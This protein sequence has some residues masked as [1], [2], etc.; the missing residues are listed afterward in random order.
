MQAPRPR[1]VRAAGVSPQGKHP[2]L[3]GPARP[4]PHQPILASKL[5]SPVWHPNYVCQCPRCPRP[6]LRCLLA[7]HAGEAWPC[8]G[9]GASRARRPE[10]GPLRIPFFPASSLPLFLSFLSSSRRFPCTQSPF[11]RCPRVGRSA[12]PCLPLL[13]SPPRPPAPHGAGLRRGLGRPSGFLSRSAWS[14]GSRGIPAGGPVPRFSGSPRARCGFQHA[15]RVW[16]G[17]RGRAAPLVRALSPARR[18]LS[19]APAPCRPSEFD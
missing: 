7:S 18:F 8:R 1:R 11:R 9:R 17:A 5:R 19:P 15:G 14:W 3:A 16:A 2:K 10:G 12:L 4:W 6:A 13:W